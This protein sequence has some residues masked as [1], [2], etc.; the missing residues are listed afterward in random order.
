MV[1]ICHRVSAQGGAAATICLVITRLAGWDPA[2]DKAT[3]EWGPSPGQTW[4]LSQLGCLLALSW[5]NP[6][7]FPIPSSFNGEIW[8]IPL[9][10]LLPYSL[11]NK[12]HQANIGDCVWQGEAGVGTGG[13]KSW[14]QLG[15]G[16][17]AGSGPGSLGSQ[18]KT[19]QL[20]EPC[21]L[22]VS[23][24]LVGASGV[25]SNTRET[26]IREENDKGGER[27]RRI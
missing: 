18:N 20:S 15:W 19:P 14:A 8:P 5:E 27:E 6:F 4:V 2:E 1:R 25:W 22:R 3:G 10:V 11:L 24:L 7:I 26:K 23:I 9:F 17:A 12:E 13:Q 21:D 16:A